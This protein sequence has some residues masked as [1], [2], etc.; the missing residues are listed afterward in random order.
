MTMKRTE[1]EKRKGLAISN[2]LRQG[3]NRYGPAQAAAPDRK[4]QREAERAAGLVPFAVK[5]PAPLVRALGERA[6][7]EA[8]GLNELV[9]A[10]LTG[11][12]DPIAFDSDASPAAA[13]NAAAVPSERR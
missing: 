3:G 10:L 4:A 11:E 6:Q 2:A 5:L 13:S 7:R 1:L 12:A 9:A 8:I